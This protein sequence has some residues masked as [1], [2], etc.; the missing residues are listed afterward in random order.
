MEYLIELF[1]NGILRAAV[2]S[3]AIAQLLKVVIA[4]IRVRRLDIGLMLSTGGMPSSH[5]AFMVA[6]TTAVGIREGFGTSAFAIAAA[7]TV[8]VMSDAAG[9]RR[10]AGKQAKVINTIVENIKNTG[11]AFD[12]KLKELLGHTPIEVACGAVLGIVVAWV[13][14]G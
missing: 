13:M 2:V 5:T 6:M 3:W 7:I 10:A 12:K 8:V 14:Y 9:V 11:V 4:F 1:D